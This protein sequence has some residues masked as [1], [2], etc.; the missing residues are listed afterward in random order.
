[1]CVIAIDSVQAK[2][3]TVKVQA[4]T[5]YAEVI[6]ESY[7]KNAPVVFK[8]AVK[9]TMKYYNKYKDADMVT[10]LRNVPKTY[11]DFVDIARKIRDSDEITLYSLHCAYIVTLNEGD[12]NAPPTYTFLAE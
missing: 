9:K 6:P 12:E 1:M 3:Y 8:K 7:L 4:D 2:A 10:Y 5:I 11:R